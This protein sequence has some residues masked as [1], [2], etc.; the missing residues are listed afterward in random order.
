MTST[1][2]QLKKGSTQTLILAVL[3]REPLHGYAVARAIESLSD[4]ALR[5][6]EGA[7]Y[8]ALR[9]LEASGF[10]NSAWEPQAAGA[11][12]RVYTLTDAGRAELADKRAQWQRFA[13][14]VT[15]VL[16]APKPNTVPTEGGTRTGLCF[17]AQ[18]KSQGRLIS[19]RQVSSSR[20]AN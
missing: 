15:R 1:D 11:A 18:G 9:A 3:E 4:D 13:D 5:M 20:Y 6:N 19:G 10:V 17:S 16:N 12:R 7:L 2:D 14:A 8:P